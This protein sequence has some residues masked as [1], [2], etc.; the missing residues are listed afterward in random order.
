MSAHV[1]TGIQ[2]RLAENIAF[3]GRALRAA[4]LPVGPGH[5]LDAVAALET[6]GLGERDD[7]YWT[8]HAVFVSRHEESVVFEQA[9]RLFFRKRAYIE[10]LMQMLMPV[11]TDRAIRPAEAASKRVRDALFD[12]IENTA[13]P[14]K[15]RIVEI[16]ATFTA[17]PDELLKSKDF[18]QM[19]AE[20]LLAARRALKRL[21]LL[22]DEVV[23]RRSIPAGKGKRVDMRRTLRAALST[24][25]QFAALRH[26][27]PER[28]KPPIVALLD[29]SGSM[30][31]YSR[32]MLHFLHALAEDG[33][34]VD[35]FL[36][37]TR[38]T[39]VTRQLKRRDP[40]EALAACTRAVPD[41]QG[42]TR[43]AASL[44][45]FNKLWSRRVLGARATVLLVTDGLERDDAGLEAEMDRL[46][47]SCRRL[48][49]LNPLLRYDGFE[50]K[51]RGVRAML[52][53]VDEFRSIHSL[54]SI[55]ELVAALGHAHARDADPKRWLR[56]G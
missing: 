56:P 55:E 14:P 6:A 51:A 47:R 45:G 1:D 50:A 41:W 30:S 26:R 12:G 13:T 18:E 31:A 29:I 2:G 52:P 32:V 27:A 34:R 49:W 53:F 19:S 35:T 9:F 17:S 8:L 10:R 36:F 46:S 43:I 4:G 40:D 22:S 11:A 3:F 44:H 48:V 21:A 7:L 24:G 42:G 39:N 28:T 20:E 15:K 16:D 25:G 33:R 54:K 23:T 38:L 37:G 5:V